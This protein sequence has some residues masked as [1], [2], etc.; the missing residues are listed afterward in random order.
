MILICLNMVK[1]DPTCA[2]ASVGERKEI[3]LKDMALYS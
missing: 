1:K 2:T 3:R